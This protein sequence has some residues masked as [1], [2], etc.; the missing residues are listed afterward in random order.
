M[1][2]TFC[3]RLGAAEVIDV[4]CLLKF[5]SPLRGGA[6]TSLQFNSP[7]PSP[8]NWLGSSR[9]HISAFSHCSL[10]PSFQTIHLIHPA[11]S[12][13]HPAP[14][15]SHPVEGT[16][17][18][19]GSGASGDNRGLNPHLQEPVQ[20]K[21]VK[22]GTGVVFPLGRGSLCDDGGVSE[23]CFLC[24]QLQPRSDT[25]TPP[26]KVHSGSFVR[27]AA[28]PNYKATQGISP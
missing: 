28:S 2:S 3:S 19:P 6:R 25:P 9:K 18:R 26:R 14:N 17:L 4:H 27:T 20:S 11:P 24:V 21:L 16:G 1:S 10:L 5:W 12:T 8:S 22:L 15:T 23:S 7:K 13:A